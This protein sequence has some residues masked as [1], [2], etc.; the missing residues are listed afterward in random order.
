MRFNL[1]GV[2]AHMPT[3]SR[4]PLRAEPRVSALPR[5]H[6]AIIFLTMASAESA[7]DPA[8]GEPSHELRRELGLRDLVLA[9]VLCVVGSG[10]VGVAAK[11][12]QAHAVFWIGSMV[13][14]YLPLAIVVI[15]LNREMPLEGGL[16]EWSRQG[17]GEMLGF[18]TGWNLWVYALVVIPSILFMIP[19][20]LA[21]LIGPA[22]TW[23]PGNKVATSLLVGLVIVGIATVAARGLGAS[24][25]LHNAGSAMIVTAYA[26]LLMLPLWPLL[27]GHAI[28]YT[29]LPVRMPSVSWFSLA[30]FGQITVGGLSG[31]EYVAI[32]A[33]ECRNPVRSIA[34]SVAISAPLIAMMFILGTSSVLAFVGTRPIDLIGPIPQTFRLAFGTAAWGAV[35]APCAIFLL[36][37]RAVAA[38]SLIFTGLTRLPMAAGWDH[39][40]P[41][42]FTALH[43]RWRTPVNSILF[44]AGLSLLFVVL[45][46]V[47]VHEQEAMQLLSNASSVHYG[48]AY[49]ALFAI[50]LLGAAGLRRR[51]PLWVKCAAAAG[52]LSSLVAVMIGT[53]PIINVS[54][55][56]SYAAKIGGTV[57]I[58]NLA[59]VIL[60]L[61]RKRTPLQ[62]RSL[63]S[64]IRR[65]I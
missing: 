55:R 27:H 57:I 37:G 20:E 26:I 53:Y 50:P 45:S 61:T 38:G 64:P 13:L 2:S 4:D 15:Y 60:Y 41:Q 48:I 17:F 44:V 24:K 11:L 43:P 36:L 12:G 35:L 29:P 1:C 34:R 49:V 46:M 7:P 6:Y 22:G 32:M 42:W 39:L 21:Y 14:F 65:R 58:S 52:L 28:A 56:V 59:G 33:G 31:F 3:R 54:S 47:G 8:L 16:Y 51:L 63:A 62:P 30:V 10:W 18:L 5:S 9:Q 19:T 25:Q 40:L 23:L